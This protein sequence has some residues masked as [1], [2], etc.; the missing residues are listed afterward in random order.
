MDK[1]WCTMTLSENP[2]AQTLKVI[3][4]SV[5]YLIS[6]WS[7]DV[8]IINHAGKQTEQTTK[9]II[10]L[11]YHAKTTK[12]KHVFFS[13]DSTLYCHLFILDIKAI[14]TVHIITIINSTIIMILIIV[15]CL[16]TIIIYSMIMTTMALVNIVMIYSDIKIY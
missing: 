10:G 8:L 15:P 16:I 14:I 6:G 7:V 2:G 5:Q 11:Q 13:S 12:K 4:A 1:P 9:N 3:D